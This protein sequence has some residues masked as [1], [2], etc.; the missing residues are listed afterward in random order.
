MIKFNRQMI[1]VLS[2]EP[3]AD[4]LKILREQ[5]NLTSLD[6][7]DLTTLPIDY[8]LD[9]KD[10]RDLLNFTE[11]SFLGQDFSGVT[12]PMGI[13]RDAC[14]INANMTMATITDSDLSGACFESADFTNA[15]FT[16]NKIHRG[17]FLD[18]RFFGTNLSNTRFFE[19]DFSRAT[20]S[21]SAC[22][23]ARFERATFDNKTVAMHLEGAFMKDCFFQYGDGVKVMISLEDEVA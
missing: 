23:G 8:V 10:D 21:H 18:A 3:R 12:F 16:N 14:F 5:F 4:A 15:I 20:I 7:E 1:N 17:D 19:C 22:L 2:S 13:Y 11:C 9:S 6:I